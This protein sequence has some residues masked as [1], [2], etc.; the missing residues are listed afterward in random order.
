MRRLQPGLE[1]QLKFSEQQ[2]KTYTATLVRTSNA[3]IPGL[4]TASRAA[5]RQCGAR[6]LSG[7]YAEVHFKLAGNA[8]SLRLPA[9]TVLV[10]SPWRKSPSST[11]SGAFN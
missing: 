3:L 11:P 1:A 8:R 7:A 5:T 6:A 4:R 10:P 2:G 9:N